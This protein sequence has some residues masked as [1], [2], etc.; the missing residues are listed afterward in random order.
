[1][2]YRTAALELVT[3]EEVDMNDL[4]EVYGTRSYSRD[5]QGILC[6]FKHLISQESVVVGN[7]HLHYNPA[8]DY[9][10]YAQAA[11][12]RGRASRFN[13]KHADGQSLPLVLCGDFNSLPVS[14]VMSVFHNENIT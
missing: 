9:L 1:M 6:L 5:N 11:Y 10:K 13:T 14:S 12:M 4:A 3:Y 2:A 8:K 7:M